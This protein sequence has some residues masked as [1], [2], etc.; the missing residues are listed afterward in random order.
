MVGIV[1]QV[2]FSLYPAVPLPSLPQVLIP[3]VVPSKSSAESLPTL[4][5]VLAPSRTQ[6]VPALQKEHV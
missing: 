4:F 6:P 3:E 5:Y 2:N 1:S